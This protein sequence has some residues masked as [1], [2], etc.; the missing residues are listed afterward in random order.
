MAEREFEFRKG[1]VDGEAKSGG[2]ITCAACGARD[3]VWFQRTRLPPTAVG[4]QFRK[5]GWEVGA[6]PRKD[7]CP[8]CVAKAAGVP[9]AA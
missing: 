3:T 1:R 5:R 4:Q 7:R 8:A 9:R 2:G 6:K